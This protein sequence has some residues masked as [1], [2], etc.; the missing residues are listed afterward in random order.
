MLIGSDIKYVEY[1]S[2][3]KDSKYV[4]GIE[5]IDSDEIYDDI[6]RLIFEFDSEG[7]VVLKEWSNEC[8]GSESIEEGKVFIEEVKSDNEDIESYSDKDIID[9]YIDNLREGGYDINLYKYNL[10]E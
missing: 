2:L 6:Y 5:L 10:D 4:Y 1:E 3:D 7:K 9:M 8:K